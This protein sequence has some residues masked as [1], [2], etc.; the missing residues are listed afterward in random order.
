[1]F[2]VTETGDKDR[3]ETFV[4]PA[5][6]SG[7]VYVRVM[8]TYR[9]EGSRKLDTV[10]VDH[11]FISTEWVPGDLPAAPTD[12]VAIPISASQINLAWTDTADNENGFEIERSPNGLADWV[13]LD[14]VVPDTTSY[15]DTSL[16][17]STTY[18]YQVRAYNKSGHSDPSNVAN[19][20]TEQGIPMHIGDLD[21]VSVLIDE[22]RWYAVV[23][24]TV[25]DQDETPVSGATV[26]GSWSSGATG[27][28]SVITDE[29]GQC[30]FTV[31]I[32]ESNVSS[33]T[34]TVDDVTLTGYTYMPDNNHDPDGDSDGTTII[35]NQP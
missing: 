22:S 33:V 32:L 2:T 8:D 29:L 5:S 23:A 11:L 12:L 27:S 24:I 28:G 14:T 30:S 31:T 13:L 7:T 20:T 16:E 18:Y 25:H 19:A 3:Y 35:V 34:F 4:L 1:M 6:T 10:Y 9:I 21:G 15:S 26:S 17:G